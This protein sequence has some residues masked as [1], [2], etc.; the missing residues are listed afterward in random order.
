MIYLA[1]YALAVARVVRVITTDRITQG[2]RERLISRLWQRHLRRM[3]AETL[4]PEEL[5]EPLTITL[6]RCPWCLSVWAGAVAA[7][8]V[9]Q[10]GRSPWLWVPALALAFSQTTGLLARGE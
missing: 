6:V 8:M 4:V 5:P 10:A 2:P 3:P 9:W 7:P 1:V